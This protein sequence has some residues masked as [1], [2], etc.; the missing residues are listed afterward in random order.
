MRRLPLLLLVVLLAV[1]PLTYRYTSVGL[2]V[3][4]LRGETVDSR[5]YRLRWP[6]DGSV[7]VGW[8][9]EHRSA[10]AEPAKGLDV[11]ALVLQ[12][13]RPMT[14]RSTWNDV[15]FW[16]E[17]VVASEGDRPSEA[18][19]RADR[20]MLVGAPHWLFVALAALVLVGRRRRSPGDTTWRG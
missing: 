11:G 7:L 2:D 17:D 1:W 12:R 14:P 20:V 15:G 4:T 8:I 13:P 10:E 3:D 6:G 19:P 18:A 5:F 16:Y 9:D